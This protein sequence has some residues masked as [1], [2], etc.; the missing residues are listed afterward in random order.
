MKTTT[1]KTEISSCRQCPFFKEGPTE[2]TDGF[3]HGNDWICQHENFMPLNK[4]GNY[5]SFGLVNKTEVPK[6]CPIR[7]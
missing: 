4:S 7:V 3:D 5:I 6:W 1:I 2:S